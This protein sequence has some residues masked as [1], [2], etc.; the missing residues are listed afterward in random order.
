MTVVVR[1]RPSPRWWVW[2]PGVERAEVVR[3]AVRRAR[4]GRARLSAA[5]GLPLCGVI[6]VVVP[7]TGWKVG[8]VAAVLVGAAVVGAVPPRVSEWDVVVAAGGGDVVHCE[9]FAD[10]GQRRRAR[11][12]CEHFLAV[13][14]VSDSPR[15]R[16]VEVS[17]WRALVALRESLAVRDALAR[18]ENRVGLAAEIAESTRDLAALDRRVDEFAAA[19]RIAVEEVAEV[20][21]GSAESALRRVAALD[22][23]HSPAPDRSAGPGI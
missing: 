20:D 16:G 17:L 15:L 5:V 3:A 10:P 9:Q 12:L 22:P 13:A 8:L 11:R 19:L 7:G 21:P 2:R 14:E 18:A 4:R 6:A 1:L 23:I